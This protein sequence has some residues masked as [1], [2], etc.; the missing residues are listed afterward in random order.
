MAQTLL[1]LLRRRDSDLHESR[2]CG[3]WF[4][5]LQNISDRSPILFAIAWTDY[6][7]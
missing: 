2:L 3:R 1:S 4:V 6:T 7:A 5:S